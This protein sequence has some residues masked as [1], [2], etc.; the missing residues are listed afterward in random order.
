MNKIPYILGATL[1][2]VVPAVAQQTHPDSTITLKE[3]TLANVTVTSR[4]ASVRSLK[5]AING[6][7]I[8]RDELFKAACC[9]LGESFVTNPS[10]DVNYADATTG[11]K[12]VKLLGLSGT[13][14]QMLTEN[15][16]NF[17]GAALP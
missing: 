11:A 9:N 7:D 3:Q 13:Y 15:L 17:R 5:G 6:K 12:Q 1:L 4:K 14:V 8:L 16:P 10:V 2:A